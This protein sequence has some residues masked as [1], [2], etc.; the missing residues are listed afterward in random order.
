MWGDDFHKNYQ[1]LDFF[2][3]FY[4]I[5]LNINRQSEHSGLRPDTS[6]LVEFLGFVWCS[7][8]VPKYNSA[9]K[10]ISS[11]VPKMKT[12]FNS[13]ENFNKFQRIKCGNQKLNGDRLQ[14]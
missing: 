11:T 10:K 14:T 3:H 1:I 2:F 5:L 9:E 12:L 6:S 7:T 4:Y 13:A 8:T